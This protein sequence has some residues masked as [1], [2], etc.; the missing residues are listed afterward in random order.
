MKKALCLILSFVFAFSCFSVCA[1]AADPECEHSYETRIV[2]PTCADDGYTLHVCTKCGDYYKENFT[3]A[4]GHFYNEWQE[5][6]AASCEQ[7]GLMQRTCKNCG[8]AETKTI[9]VTPHVDN[10]KDGKC[11][12]CDA[13][14][15]VKTLFSPFDWLVSFFKAVVEW[16]RE[17]FA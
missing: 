10:N 3:S 15:E 6:H 11:D 9:P 14:V 2:P 1:F 16:F 13:P 5:E 8:A 4:R 7:E 17:I 12:F